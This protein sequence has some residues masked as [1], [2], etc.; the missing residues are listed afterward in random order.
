MLH[1]SSHILTVIPARGGSIRVPDKNIRPFAG[2]PLIVHTI[3]QALKS[4][5]SER[6]IVDTDSPRIAQ[7]AKKYGAEVPFLRPPELATADAK[8]AD[9]LCFLLGRL[10]KEEKYKPEYLLLLQATSP[11]RE[12]EDIRACSERM[13]VENAQTVLTVC[14]AQPR[15]DDLVFVDATG[16]VSG[17][18][19][20]QGVSV[21]RGCT[22]AVYLIRVA[23]F[24]K[25]RKI[26]M[27]KTAT[28][29]CPSWRSID[30]DTMEDWAVAE[31]LFSR[32]EEIKKAIA[33]PL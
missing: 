15:H 18:V 33:H 30:I 9:A 27:N 19:A 24:L 3:E 17:D 7:I 5:I 22:G 29:L 2:K 13:R 6:V 8:V 26:I 12:V 11:L 1:S 28:V 4:D 25:T 20:P 16:R 14:P 21:L 10:H 31:T 23:D 32:R